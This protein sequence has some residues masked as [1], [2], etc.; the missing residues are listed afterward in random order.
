MPAAG[1]TIADGTLVRTRFYLLD[2]H[3]HPVAAGESLDI[4]WLLR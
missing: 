2:F 4:F 1:C 3:H